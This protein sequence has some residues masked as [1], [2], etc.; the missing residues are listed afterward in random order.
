[1]RCDGCMQYT[2]RGEC[3]GRCVSPKPARWSPQDKYGSYRAE[4]K[5]KYG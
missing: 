5:K 4:Y 2:I 1:M 3:C